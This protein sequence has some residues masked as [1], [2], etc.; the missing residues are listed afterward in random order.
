METSTFCCNEERSFLANT[1]IFT[2][3]ARWTTKVSQ[4]TKL[5]PSQNAPFPFIRLKPFIDDQQISIHAKYEHG[6]RF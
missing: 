3:N 5:W 4:P 6:I 1:Y 2:V